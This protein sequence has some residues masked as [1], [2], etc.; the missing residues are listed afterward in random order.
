M[1]GGWARRAL[2]WIERGLVVG[3]VACL[4]WA[5]MTWAQAASYQQSAKKAVARLLEARRLPGEAGSW[6]GRSSAHGDPLIGV[7]EIPRVGVSAAVLEGDDDQSLSIAVGH[8][9][10]ADVAGS[11]VREVGARLGFT[12]PQARTVGC[13]D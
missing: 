8:L 13:T 10:G 5:L 9:P 7:L 11:G 3:G 2:P 4:A 1:G 12:R 6:R